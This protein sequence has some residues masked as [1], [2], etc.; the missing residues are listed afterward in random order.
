MIPQLRASSF[1]R[2]VMLGS[3]MACIGKPHSDWYSAFKKPHVVPTLEY[4]DSK[5]A[6]VLFARQMA[7][8]FPNITTVSAHPVPFFFALVLPSSPHSILLSSLSCARALFGPTYLEA[9]L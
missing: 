8:K 9:V 1:P 5:L 4:A 6:N 3:I 2:V 7:V